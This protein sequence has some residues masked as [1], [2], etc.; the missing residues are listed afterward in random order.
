[1]LV[2]GGGAAGLTAAVLLHQLGVEFLL[3]N[4]REAAS[5]LPRAH[6]INQ[7]TM[8]VLDG[9][10]V[11]G[12]V[13]RL[14]TPAANMTHV[15]WYT[16]VS[17][18]RIGVQELW[19][20]GG[21]N[22]AWAAAS[23]CR[24][25]NLPQHLLEELL[26]REC[27][28]DRIRFGHRVTG[29]SQQDG[30]VTVDVVAGTSSYTVEA[31]YVLAC[32]GGRTIGPALGIPSEGVEEIARMVSVHFEAD[33]SGVLAD[34]EVLMRWLVRPE[35][36]VGVSLLP[37]GPDEWGTRSREWVLHLN[38]TP[39]TPLSDEE[40][41]RELC[42][43]LE[44]PTPPTV[45]RIMRW[46]VGSTVAERFRDGRVFLLGDAAHRLPPTGGLGLNSAVQD[47]HNLVWK[48]A[49]VLRGDAGAELLDTYEDER[50]PVAA[51]NIHQAVQNAIGH[52]LI[53]QTLG[54]G[55]ESDPA[56]NAIALRRLDSGLPEDREFRDSV[57][58]AFA[59]QA[60]EFDAL[61]LEYGYTYASAAVVPDDS[62]EPD[63]PDPVRVYRPGTRP[64]SPLP[65]AW[66]EDP[67]GARVAL[68]S[69][70][71]PGRWL[72]IAGEDDGWTEAARELGL[73][74]DVV[75]IGQTRGD[76][77]DPRSAWTAV[78]GTSAG[79]AVLVRPDR[80]VAWRCADA[81]A[82]PAA[83]LRAAFDAVTCRDVAIAR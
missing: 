82:D 21:H 77:L 83:A 74:L 5:R 4:S 67:L 43:V 2:V 47:A 45:H 39:D 44:L 69:L 52:L 71:R 57:R 70:V 73:P 49:A 20:A 72:L 35:T 14:G 59:A 17:G 34:D 8:E 36:G 12:E 58:Q 32:D 6:V 51:A 61:N 13:Y 33:L 75:R 76:Y 53:V 64:G 19:G 29:V 27:P 37:L 28:P 38:E 79:G 1:M 62:P 54:M 55:P 48:L 41:R 46:T 11:A 56:E 16:G 30:G 18:R 25:A 3:L 7:R 42:S 80:V 66:L 50:K 63:N 15:G 22:P 60:G 10:G 31:D 68:G 81:V 23:P 24:T 40:A 9:I 78:R 26:L 65:H